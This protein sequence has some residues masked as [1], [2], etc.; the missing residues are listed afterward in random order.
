M[1]L[2][3]KLEPRRVIEIVKPFGALPLIH[4]YL[5]YIQ[6][7]NDV[8]VNE[9]LNNLYIEEENYKALRESIDNFDNF[10]KVEVAMRLADHPLIEFRRIST[11]LFKK[12]EKWDRSIEMSKKDNLWQDAM[13]TCAQSGNPELANDLLEHFV[14]AGR[15]E[16]FAA[17]LYTC[18]HLLKPDVVMEIA[19]RKNLMDFAMPF[20]IQTMQNYDERLAAIQGRLD[21]ADDAVRAEEDEKKKAEE[22][23]QATDAAYVGA[24][25]VYNPMMAPLPLPAPGA[26]YGAQQGYGGGYG[27]GYGQQQQGGFFG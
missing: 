6:N 11:H 18:F 3:A 10:D 13:E 14:D 27:G 23:R 12:C 1:D 7:K 15:K 2:H 20:M 9:A 24:Q 16:C 19:W 25:N 21:A 26:A 17:M 5:A 4:K 8:M 22:Q